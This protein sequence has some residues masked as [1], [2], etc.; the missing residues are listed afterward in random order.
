MDKRYIWWDTELI[1]RSR[2]NIMKHFEKENIGLI[3]IRRSRSQNDWNFVLA[4]DKMIAGA[5]AITSLDINYLFPLFRYNGNGNSNGANY[6]FKEDDKKDNFTEEFRKF[7]KTK[8]KAKPIDKKQI[9]E[10]EKTIKG[11]EKQLKQI[12]KI[13]RT[14]EKTNTDISIINLQKQ[15]IEEIK[16]QIEQKQQ[17]LKS[18]N[19][20]HNADYEPTTEEIF[21]YIYAVLHSHTFRKKYSEFLKMDFPRIPFV[22]TLTQFQTLSKLGEELVKKHLFKEIPNDDEY[23]KIGNFKGQG[24]K[25]VIK[26]DFVNNKLYINKTQYF[27]TVPEQVYNF[28]VGGYQ[29]LDKYLKDRKN[30]TL[31]HDEI[32]NIENI[33]KVLTFT[34][35]QMELIDNE[36]K[37]WI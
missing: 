12:E 2:E 21:N 19:I 3:T 10:I 23:N 6:L 28:Y 4:T 18:A 22:E 25:T 5:T 37:E 31:T 30:R 14:F 17:E 32:E 24:D 33:V 27:E 29:V 15:T 36:T 7:I 16:V 34:I 8:Y 9:A 20:S 13:I 1:E 11:H 26:P 35:K